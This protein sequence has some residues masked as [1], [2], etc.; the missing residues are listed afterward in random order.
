MGKKKIT[1]C[2]SWAEVMVLNDM[3]QLCLDEAGRMA[4]VRGWDA[5]LGK[6]DPPIGAE[7]FR[8]LQ[9]AITDQTGPMLIKKKFAMGRDWWNEKGPPRLRKVQ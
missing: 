3:A 8:S 5:P 4:G 2:L 6:K 7:T 9:W 1:L